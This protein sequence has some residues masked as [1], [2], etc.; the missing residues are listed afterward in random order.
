[1][2][3]KQ[4]KAIPSRATKVRAT[5]TIDG[6]LPS[7]PPLPKIVNPFENAPD[8]PQA[9]HYF[10]LRLQ[11]RAGIKLKIKIL[12]PLDDWVLIELNGVEKYKVGGVP[13]PASDLAPYSYDISND[14][15]NPGRYVYKLTNFNKDDDH[16]GPYALAFELAYHNPENAPLLEFFGHGRATWIK[17]PVVVF[18]DLDVR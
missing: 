8:I 10:R 14:I 18:V 3:P 15:H 11:L 2:K 5:K 4:T 6:L 16:S 17:E 12:T 7:L 1:M 13:S 9:P